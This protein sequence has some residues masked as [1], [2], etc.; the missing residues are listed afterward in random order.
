VLY[1]AMNLFVCVIIQTFLRGYVLLIVH[2]SEMFRCLAPLL[3]KIITPLETCHDQLGDILIKFR[4]RSYILF[5]LVA[6]Q[7][8]ANEIF[9]HF[10]VTCCYGVSVHLQLFC[11]ATRLY[12]LCVM[13]V[14]R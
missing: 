3:L 11:C 9:V 5:L 8:F 2:F 13:I 10:Y 7:R 12:L 14:S 6:R 4:N 1:L